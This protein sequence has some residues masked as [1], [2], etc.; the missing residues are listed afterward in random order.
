MGVVEARQP[1]WI[2]VYGKIMLSI[3]I[4]FIA[5]PCS[6]ARRENDTACHHGTC[7]LSYELKLDGIGVRGTGRRRV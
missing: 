2:R 3:S 7:Y 1:A 5:G 6:V 4:K